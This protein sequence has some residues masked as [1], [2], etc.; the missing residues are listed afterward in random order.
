[1]ILALGR[2]FATEI[3]PVL[4]A[5]FAAQ[6]NFHTFTG[7]VI[8]TRTLQ[9][10]SQPLV[11]TGQVWIAI[12]DRFRWEIG[13]PAQTIALRQPDGLSIVYPRLKRVAKY[14]LTDRQPGPWRDMLALLDASFPRSRAELETQFR[15]L[16]V[17]TTNAD[18]VVTLEPKSTFARRMMA[19]I[20][21]SVRTNDFLL[22]ATEMKFADGSRMRND[23]TET[24]TNTVLPDGCFDLKLEPDY[25]VVEP[26]RQ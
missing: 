24:Q 4:D 20:A 15:V 11:S 3:S 18:W 9:A 8:Q 7:K 2:G 17:S 5:W 14:P 19:G 21:I 12:P 10:L 23:F 26:L 16:S 13:Q 1:M 6:T 25:K 22:T